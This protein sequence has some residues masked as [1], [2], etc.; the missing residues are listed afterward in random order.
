MIPGVGAEGEEEST[1]A[2]KLED[3]VEPGVGHP[4]AV[5]VIDAYAVGSCNHNEATSQKK[6]NGGGRGAC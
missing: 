5:G 6:L 1:R 4:D 2:I 3:L